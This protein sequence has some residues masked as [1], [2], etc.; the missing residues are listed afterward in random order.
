[1]EGFT[2]LLSFYGNQIAKSLRF[3][4]VLHQSLVQVH[5]NFMPDAAQAVNRLL[6]DL[7]WSSVSP[8]F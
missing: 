5:A 6:L 4:R 2:P 7:S 3:S 1:M 8:Q